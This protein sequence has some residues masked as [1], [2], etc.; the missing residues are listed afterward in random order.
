MLNKRELEKKIKSDIEDRGCIVLEQRNDDNLIVGY[1]INEFGSKEDKIIG[2]G[3]NELSLKVN[4]K[5]INRA[6]KEP[7]IE[8]GIVLTPD[9]TYY[10]DMSTGIQTYTPKTFKNHSEY[11]TSEE[12]IRRKIGY[13]IQSARRKYDGDITNYILTPIAIRAYFFKNNNLNEWLNV[14]IDLYNQLVDEIKNKLKINGNM[15]QKIYNKDELEDTKKALEMLVPISIYYSRIIEDLI[16]KES[17]KREVDISTQNMINVVSDFIKVL[18]I[19]DSCIELGSGA[20]CILREQESNFNILKGIEINNDISDI[21]KLLNLISGKGNIEITTTDALDIEEVEK[22]GLTIVEPPLGERVDSEPYRDKSIV[23]RNCKMINTS[24]LLLEK[25]INLTKDGGYIVAIVNDG[26]LFI[27]QSEIIRKLITNKTTVKAIVGLPNHIQKPYTVAKMSIVI[28]KKKSSSLECCEKVFINEI[29]KIDEI[30]EV[31]NQFSEFIQNN[32]DDSNLLDYGVLYESNNWTANYLRMFRELNSSNR[33]L[34]NELCNINS[35]GI[36]TLINEKEKYPYIEVSN[37]DTDKKILK[38][39]KE[40]N[41]SELPSR[42]KLLAYPGDIVIS[43]ARPDKGPIAIVPN[44]YDVYIV[45]SALA[46]LSPKNISAE[47]LYFILSSNKVTQE[48]S[49]LASGT[50]VPMIMIKQLKEYKLPISDIPNQYEKEAKELYKKMLM[51]YTQH[52]TLN[53]IIDETLKNIDEVNTKEYKIDEVLSYKRPVI[54][55]NEIEVKQVKIANL[56]TESLYVNEKDLALFD[57]KE[58]RHNL[59]KN[60]DILIPRVLDSIERTSVA[61]T[62]IEGCIS[63]QVIYTYSANEV[64]LPEYM[65]MIFRSSQV[66]EKLEDLAKA[67]KTRAMIKRDQIQSIVIKLPTIEIQKNIVEKVLSKS[68]EYSLSEINREKS[69]FEEKLV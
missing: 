50:A 18:N 58:G 30:N 38:D 36:K 60:K 33:Y 16:R 4:H 31:A 46:V 69:S 26:L 54:L 14:D 5:L 20:G 45:S 28:M 51:K 37:I 53:Q 21:S 9:K 64:V 25:A 42:A 44:D 55:K 13:L 7:T 47:L 67:S 2:I 22:Y 43:T 61:N 12:D 11:A 1:I 19:N 8:L 3:V 41:Y 59:I 65:A 32:L 23:S 40:V 49:A 15:L 68:K 62:N 66:K 17:V 34:L 56:N 27:K 35:H 24:D 39:I 57:E 10:I 52:K 48:L 6:M 29:S 63:N